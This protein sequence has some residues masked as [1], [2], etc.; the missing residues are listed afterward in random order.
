MHHFIN[1]LKTTHMKK[2]VLMIIAGLFFAACNQPAGGE[3]KESTE[4]NVEAVKTIK[5][6]VTGMT[7]EGCENTVMKALNGL[8]GV[9]LSSASHIDERAEVSFDTTLT[10][11]D[12]IALAIEGVGYSVEGLVQDEDT[13]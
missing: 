7:C 6:H 9:T 13:E 11:L 3:Q 1:S 4:V 12:E 10:S 8:E 2:I 5:L